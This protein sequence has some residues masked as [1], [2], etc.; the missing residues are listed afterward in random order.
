MKRVSVLLCVIAI[1]LMNCTSTQTTSQSSGAPSSQTP[2]FAELGLTVLSTSPLDGV[3]DVAIALTSTEDVELAYGL[4]NKGAGEAFAKTIYVIH[5]GDNGEWLLAATFPANGSYEVQLLGKGKSQANYAKV[6]GWDVR[7]EIPKGPV[8]YSAMSRFGLKVLSVSPLDGV[9]DLEVVLSSPQDLALSYELVNKAAAKSNT[10]TLYNITR[11]E[12]GQWVLAVAFPS[13]GEYK[14]ILHG[15]G[16]TQG[17]SELVASWDV[18]AQVPKDAVTYSRMSRYGLKVESVSALQGV[19]DA[20][21]VLSCPK[22]MELHYGLI[23]KTAGETYVKLIYS[24][25]GAV[26]GHYIV[27]TPFPVNADYTIVLYGWAK[28]EKQDFSNPLGSWNARAEIPKDSVIYSGFKRYGLQLNYSTPL[29]GVADAEFA[30]SSKQDLELLY[31]I[32]NTTAGETKEKSLTY[33]SKSEGGPWT[34]QT[35]FPQSGDYQVNLWGGP[36]GTQSTTLL[37]RW[38]FH[39]DVPKDAVMYSR[40]A[41]YGLKVA[42]ATPLV[43]V[44]D[45]E[46]VLASSQDLVLLYN[47]QDNANPDKYHT[48]H[49]FSSQNGQWRLPLYFTHSGDYELSIEGK[50]SFDPGYSYYPLAHWN[51]RAEV[52]NGTVTYSTFKADSLKVVSTSALQGA[53]DAQIVLAST[54]DLSLMAYL[55]DMATKESVQGVKVA[56]RNGTWTIAALFPKTGDYVLSVQEWRTFKQSDGSTESI[57]YM[58]A[59]WVFSAR[60]DSPS[61]QYLFGISDTIR[62]ITLSEETPVEDAKETLWRHVAKKGTLVENLDLPFFASTLSVKKGSEIRF[63]SQDRQIDQLSCTL[64]AAAAFKVKDSVLQAPKGAEITFTTNWEDE[65]VSVALGQETTFNVRKLPLRCSDVVHFFPKDGGFDLTLARAAPMSFGK[66][67]LVIPA[68]SIVSFTG[69]AQTVSSIMLGADLTVPFKG[70]SRKAAAGWTVKVD[71]KGTIT[72]VYQNNYYGYA[73]GY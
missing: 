67:R 28:G 73:E 2:L 29:V 63:W 51:I 16:K 5:R 41:R 59:R 11:Q 23:N 52:P 46:I 66:T 50:A 15:K 32:V 3:P 19:P 12:N 54:K 35:A 22:E 18:R 26:N 69:D 62:R 27:S 58:L 48:F 31:G 9:P 55:D 37:A 21:I 30:V 53:A 72:D 43:G 38:N 64:P 44:T 25:G 61:P 17:S 7:A 70:E 8:T 24:V 13:D 6:A 56:K 33:L 10:T 45:A 60:V 57:P 4:V 42:S 71:D 20:E 14:V 39:A 40:F 68:K 34:F 36:K 47:L 65:Q 1:A 49:G